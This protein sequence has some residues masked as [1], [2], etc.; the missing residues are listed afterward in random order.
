MEA[1]RY[2]KGIRSFAQESVDVDE[3]TELACKVPTV[4]VGYVRKVLRGEYKLSPYQGEFA[5]QR[6]NPL[7]EEPID[8][9]T[10]C[11]TGTSPCP[12]NCRS[13]HV[14]ELAENPN[15]GK[16]LSWCREFGEVEDLE[17]LKPEADRK[18]YA[19]ITFAERSG[20]QLAFWSL[21]G[22]RLNGK[23]GAWGSCTMGCLHCRG[24]EGTVH[25]GVLCKIR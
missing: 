6:E 16:L 21:H 3:L 8:G 18:A 13:I 1:C 9:K 22:M 5:L 12:Q 7:D 17:T 14:W 23:V 2:V 10:S 15:L 11:P 25:T 24:L 19:R 20:A 4:D